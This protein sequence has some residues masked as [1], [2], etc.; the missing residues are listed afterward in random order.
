MNQQYLERYFGYFRKLRRDRK[1]GGAPHKPILLLAIAELVRRGEIASEQVVISPELVLAFKAIWAKVVVTPHQPNF[2]LPFFH[3]RSEPF[4]SLVAFPGVQVAVTSSG[5][6]KSFRNLRET[7]QYAAMDEDLFLLMR[8]PVG[9]ELLQQ[10]LLETYF[11]DTKANLRPDVYEESQRELTDQILNEPPSEYRRRMEIIEQSAS[12]ETL[13]EEYFARGGV[14]KREIPRLYGF[15]CA[16]TGLHIETLNA[17]QMVDACHIV[18]FALSKDDTI[19]NG[20]CLTPTIHRAFDRG[21]LTITKDYEVRISKSLTEN[22]SPYGIRQFEGKTVL[23]PENQKY[24]PS[25]ENLE[26]HGRERFDRYS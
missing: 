9:N 6:V 21:L 7:V 11:P 4:W 26:W 22:D 23:L 5:S 8:D 24:F 10:C 18:P 16:V 13:D 1:F 17:V 12:S 19:S 2:A 15:R 3:M 14:F 25:R 20:I